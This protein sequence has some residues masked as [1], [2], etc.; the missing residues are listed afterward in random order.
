MAHHAIIISKIKKLN[1]SPICGY[2][3]RILPPNE[4][5]QTRNLTFVCGIAGNENLYSLNFKKLPH[6][7]CI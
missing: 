3:E 4:N 1:M 7:Q 6:L 5:D 2:F